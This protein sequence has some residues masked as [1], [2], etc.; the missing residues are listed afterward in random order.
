MTLESSSD[1]EATDTEHCEEPAI[2]DM[3]PST[4]AKRHKKEEY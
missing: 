1:K 2:E 3:K 4:S